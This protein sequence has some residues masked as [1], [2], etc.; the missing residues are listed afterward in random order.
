MQ[1]RASG[2]DRTELRKLPGERGTGP[3]HGGNQVRK[4]GLGQHVPLPAGPVVEA[5][6]HPCDGIAPDRCQAVPSRAEAAGYQREGNPLRR[7]REDPLIVNDRLRLAG[8]PAEAHA[9][10]VNGRTPLEWLIGRSRVSRDRPSGI[11]NDPNAWFEDPRVLIAAIRRVVH[12]S[13]E[14]VRFVDGR[15]EPFGDEVEEE[16]FRGAHGGLRIAGTGR[17]PD[18]L[19][20]PEP[21]PAGG[22]AQLF[23]M[24][25]R[26][27]G[28]L[29]AFGG[30]AP[31]DPA[32]VSSATPD[33][34]HPTRGSSSIAGRPIFAYRRASQPPSWR[35][36]SRSPHTRG[37]TSLVAPELPRQEFSEDK[38]DHGN[39]R[40]CERHSCAAATGPPGRCA[41]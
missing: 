2:E 31:M 22:A 8:I 25:E 5:G 19:G 32:W 9:Y 33:W 4:P 14:T 34:R 35:P 40:Y 41:S 7:R 20:D 18:P 29:P 39:R 37:P 36:V 16:G 3:R 30:S 38:R 24:F 12:L 27:C 28:G 21:R 23:A 10:H 17:G 26:T 15:P 11:V 1:C 6:A 13:V